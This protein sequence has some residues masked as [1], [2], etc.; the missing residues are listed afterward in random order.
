MAMSAIGNNGQAQRGAGRPVSTCYVRQAEVKKARQI[1]MHLVERIGARSQTVT[2]CL[3]PTISRRQSL[4]AA[5]DE[6][7]I[8]ATLAL[9]NASDA[10]PD[11]KKCTQF[12]K[13][14]GATP[15]AKP[16][17]RPQ[18]PSVREFAKVLRVPRVDDLF[19]DPPSGLPVFPE[20]MQGLSLRRRGA[21]DEKISHEI[22]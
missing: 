4:G 16:H 1:K 18:N 9:G 10:L 20:R 8:G 19:T 5:V 11:F 12:R 6:R 14:K 22:S 3:L 2:N 13:M 15:Q 21:T 17:N 7:L